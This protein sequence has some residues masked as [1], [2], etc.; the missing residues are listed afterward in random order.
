LIPEGP[1][2]GN[3]SFA[4]MFFTTWRERGLPEAEIKERWQRFCLREG[5]N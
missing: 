5:L 4:T 3:V 2:T 1:G